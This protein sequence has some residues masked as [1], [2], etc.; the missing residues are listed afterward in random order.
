MKQRDALSMPGNYITVNVIFTV[1][2]DLP[3][4]LHN[5]PDTVG[6]G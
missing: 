4:T 6:D 2:V 5:L 1:L 3:D